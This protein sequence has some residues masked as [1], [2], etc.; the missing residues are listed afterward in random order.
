MTEFEPNASGV[1]GGV[2]FGNL[3][4]GVGGGGKR[5]HLALD[6][7]VIDARTSRIL[8]ATSVE[9]KATD[10]GGL[11]GFQIGGG[12]SELGIGLGGFS[13]TPMEKA[14]RI[15]LREAVNFISSRA[16]AEYYRH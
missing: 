16:P 10:V 13:K 15:A 6:L 8:A 9:G 3:P 12:K 1:G 5:A 2:I 11:G 14:I 4:I 7:R